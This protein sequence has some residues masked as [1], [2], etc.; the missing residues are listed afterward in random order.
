MRRKT[1]VTLL[2]IGAMSGGTLV[3]ADTEVP[4]QPLQWGAEVNP[5]TITMQ[6]LET[7]V[8]RSFASTRIFVKWNAPFPDS[9]QTWLL[10]TGHELMLSVR[11]VRTDGTQIPYASIIAAEPGSS[12]YN[13]MEAWV[14][15]LAALGVSVWF[16]YHHEPMA[17]VSSSLGTAADYVL[18][19]QKW[20][21]LFR[22]RDATNVKFMWIAT[23]QSFWL[24]SGDRRAAPKWYPGDTYVDGIG[25][26][27]YNWFNCR[28]GI[29]N[30]WKSL[31]E[32]IEPMR[33]FGLLHPDEALYLTEWASAEDP[34][35]PGRKAQWITDAR[36]LF[37]QPGWE[38]FDGVDYFNL[39]GQGNCD[40][41]VTSSTSA[42]AAF[43]AMGAD[44]FYGGTAQLL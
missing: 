12:I 3:R 23:D 29:V 42:G 33:Q 1:V 7:S 14:D 16:T 25:G 8:G 41:R 9:Y 27:A 18:A 34:A 6:N 43:A 44:P 22:S 36:N 4:A 10:N 20:V 30:R 15:R 21:D 35:R 32:I 19:W 13:E 38:Q 2:L 5:T 11:S 37:K 31:R 24:G 26:D 40:W 39:R 17:S 28:T